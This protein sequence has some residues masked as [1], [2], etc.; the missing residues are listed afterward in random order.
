M[1]LPKAEHAPML[2]KRAAMFV[3]AV[4]KIEGRV[5]AVRVF[6][7]NIGGTEV[8]STNKVAHITI[9]V[10]RGVNAKPVESN[11]IVSWEPL[12]ADIVL[13]GTLCVY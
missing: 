8:K 9:A 3:D 5:A 2:G 13:R 11:N 12:K 7:C 1:G 6:Y 10:N 4:G